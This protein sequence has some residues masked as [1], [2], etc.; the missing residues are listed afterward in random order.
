M[1]VTECLHTAEKLFAENSIP[2]PQESAMY[3]TAHVLGHKTVSIGLETLTIN[4]FLMTKR[5]EWFEQIFNTRL[6]V[7][8]VYMIK[9][10]NNDI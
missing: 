6:N 4:I 3:L 9:I 1:T 5:Q 2:E 8:C 10:E 7:K